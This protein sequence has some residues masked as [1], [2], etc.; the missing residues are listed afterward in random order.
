MERL[1]RKR[2]PLRTSF[3]KTLNILKAELEQEVPC[4]GTILDALTKIETFIVDLKSLDENIMDLMLDDKSCDESSLANEVEECEKYLDELITIKRRVNEFLNVDNS[5]IRSD[6][7]NCNV[8]SSTSVKRYKLP[9]LNIK[10]FDSQLINYLSFWSQFKKIHE[11]TELEDCDKFQYLLQSVETGTRARQLLESYPLTSENYSKAVAA[12]QERFGNKDMLMEVYVREFLKL[13]ISN[14]QASGKNRLPLSDLYMKVEAYLR[15]LESMGLNIETNSAWLYPMIESSLPEDIIKAWQRYP[16]VGREKCD[17]FNTNGVKS[18]LTLLMEFLKQEV[19]G[20]ERLQLARSGFEGIIPKEK[21]PEKIHK[22]DRIPTTA[23]LF[24]GKEV[25]CLFCSKAHESK[26]CISARS[27]SLEEKKAKVKEKNCCLKCLRYGHRANLCKIFIRCHVCSKPHTELFCPQIANQKKGE[28]KD[29]KGNASEVLQSTVVNRQ[30][31]KEIALMTLEVT[32]KNG[33]R[34]KKVR[35]LFDS[36]SQKSYILASTAKELGLKPLSTETVAHS[37]FGGAQT[38][39]KLYSNFR[40]EILTPK[41]NPKKT[42]SFEFLDQEKICGDIPRVPKGPLLRQLKKHKLW[43]SD[44]GAGCPEI[45]ILFGSDV[46]GQLMTGQVKH[47][48]RGL[49]AIETKL[50]WTICGPLDS[51]SRACWTSGTA[52]LSTNLSLR[53]M[54]VPE[55]WKLETIGIT[56]PVETLSKSE[57]EELAHDHFI[58]EMTRNSGGRYCTSLPWINRKQE[59]PLKREVLEKRKDKKKIRSSTGKLKTLR[60][61][62]DMNSGFQEW[63]AEGEISKVLEKNFK[64]PGQLKP[65]DLPSRGCTPKQLVK[66]R[67]WEVRKCLTQTED[68]WP[69]SESSLNEDLTMSEKPKPVTEA[70]VSGEVEQLKSYERISKFSKVIDMLCWV[71]R[72]ILKCKIKNYSFL[73]ELSSEVT[74]PLKWKFISPSASWWCG[75]WE[76][77]FRSVKTLLLRTQFRNK[78]RKKYLAELVQRSREKNRSVQKGDIVLMELNNQKRQNWP[79]AKV[80]KIFSSRDG[81]ARVAEV[82]TS[83]GTFVCPL[84]KLFP[85]DISDESDP[86]IQTVTENRSRSGRVIKPINK[87][88]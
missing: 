43:L 2:A 81:Y 21:A 17:T 75:W 67:W 41:G 51:P 25:T 66:T 38:D 36:G 4:K 57:E 37:L 62:R 30:C 15:S 42:F 60:N 34:T 45:E 9:K 32:I 69:K 54:K 55:L 27:M 18:K 29:V 78:F 82:K 16:I 6:V 11:D 80:L 22:R 50:G 28:V 58:K 79:I 1:K 48:H 83:S 39:A 70:L 35:G 33:N 63:E 74:S 31:S 44:I 10:P 87:T 71:R 12:F 84:R 46:Y 52:I 14:V 49:T 19:V 86:V 20:E 77:L 7:N 26:D 68:K 61:T 65:V 72:F 64:I 23:G 40:V 85:L 56:D 73:S 5:V 8:N 13:V 53:D 47:L 3:T 59:I 76:R 24:A 88:I